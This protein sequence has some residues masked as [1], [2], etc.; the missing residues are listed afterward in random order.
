MKRLLPAFATI[1]LLSC[2]SVH[3]SP[4]IRQPTESRAVSCE[5]V[6][7]DLFLGLPIQLL[8]DDGR[9]FINDF[10]T[11]PMISACDPSTGRTVG[12]TFRIGRGPGEEQPPLLL[13]PAPGGPEVF[14]RNTRTL[15]SLRCEAP[16]GALHAER[17][18][19]V[20]DPAVSTIVALDS[21]R[22]LASGFFAEGRYALL[23]RTGA[24]IAYTGDYPDFMPGEADL[25]RAG[26]GMFHQS[27]FLK[28]SPA[29]RRLASVTAHTLDLYEW[30][31]REL[32]AEARIALAPYEYSCRAGS[33]IEAR[34]SAGTP[35]GVV[36]ASATPGRIYLLWDPNTAADRSARNREIWVYDW[37]GNP[38]ERLLPDRNPIVLAAMP[39]DSLLFAVSE[40]SELLRIGL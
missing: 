19:A 7:T 5:R 6:P 35:K 26:R 31:G 13:L 27:L 8:I 15:Y 25:P 14:A 23:D 40:E 11:S 4:D 34:P 29:D 39:S 38:V 10:K 36:A 21:C 12:R 17:R 32:L 16:D 22:Y 20:F 18:P 9:L 2:T 37:S 3:T 30:N 28:K 24:T 33:V 1:F